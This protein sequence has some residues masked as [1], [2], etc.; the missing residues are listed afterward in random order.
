[1]QKMKMSFFVKLAV[2]VLAL[3]CLFIVVKNKIEINSLADR[4]SDLE[5]KVAAENEKVGELQN[6]LDTPFDREFIAAL[7]KEKLNLVMPDEVIF[8]NDL[9][10]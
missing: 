6:R 5:I 7:A 9:S 2:I 1:M 8:Y 10:E 3:V 4:K